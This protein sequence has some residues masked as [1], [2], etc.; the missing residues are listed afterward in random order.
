LRCA[1]TGTERSLRDCETRA[2]YCVS[3]SVRIHVG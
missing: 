2:A 1:N 3:S